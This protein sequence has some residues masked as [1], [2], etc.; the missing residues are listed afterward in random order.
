[1]PDF[2]WSSAYVSAVLETDLSKMPGRIQEDRAI[3]ER[4]LFASG[5]SLEMDSSE[6]KAMRD[7]LATLKVLR[8][9]Q[10]ASV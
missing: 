9:E 8:Q 2:S 5:H 6:F 4:Q 1:M 7:A 3:N 10:A